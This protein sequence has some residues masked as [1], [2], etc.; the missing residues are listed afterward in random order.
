MKTVLFRAEDVLELIER[1]G[2]FDNFFPTDFAYARAR[3]TTFRGA[4]EWIAVLEVIGYETEGGF[5]SN[6]MSACG[7]K[8]AQDKRGIRGPIVD[9]LRRDY[10]RE[11]RWNWSIVL[12]PSPDSKDYPY[13]EEDENGVVLNPL[14]FTVSVRGYVRR[15]ALTGKDYAAYGI[16]VYKQISNPR[17]DALIKIIRYLCFAQ[18]ESMFHAP[19][20]ILSKLGRNEAMPIVNI[21]NRES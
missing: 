3:L 19:A 5:V 7:N 1:Y 2:C 10:C 15:Y 21:R 8:L 20:E 16:D 12:L 13:F 11:P 17:I 9:L 4:D 14:D 18:P 6:I